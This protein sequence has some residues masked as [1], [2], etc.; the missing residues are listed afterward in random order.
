MGWN[1]GVSFGL[2]ASDGVLGRWLLPAFAAVVVVGLLVW[3]WRTE[4][5]W[6][7]IALGLIMGGA[8]GNLVDRVRYGAVADFL[9]LH[10]A[11]Y[12]WPAFNAADTG[13]TVGAAM[14]VLD[15]LFGDG[16]S[17]KKGDER[18]GKKQ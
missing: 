7:G 12:H 3:L 5:R 15:S 17:H 13:I 1:T 18:G 9:D 11:G 16:E 2:F 10:L 4:S 6:T 8:V 14:L